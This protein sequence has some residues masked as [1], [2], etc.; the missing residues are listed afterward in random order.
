[1]PLGKG[2]D[3][4][5]MVDL[6]RTAGFKDQDHLNTSFPVLPKLITTFLNLLLVKKQLKNTLAWF[7]NEK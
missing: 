7:K 4:E 3:A 5:G 6:D 2:P 1:M